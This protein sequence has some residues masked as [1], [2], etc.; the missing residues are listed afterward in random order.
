MKFKIISASSY[1][2]LHEKYRKLLK[3]KF[4]FKEETEND[5][6]ITI[7]TLEEMEKLE[8]IIGRHDLIINFIRKTIMIYDYYVE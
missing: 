1:F 3:G 4:D 6:T 7:N 8:K 2:M 5:H